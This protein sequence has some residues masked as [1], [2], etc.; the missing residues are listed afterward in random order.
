MKNKVMGKALSWVLSAAMALTMSGAIPAMTTNVYADGTAAGT[1]FASSLVKNDKIYLG[2]TTGKV[3]NSIVWDVIKEKSGDATGTAGYLNIMLDAPVVYGAAT[4]DGLGTTKGYLSSELAAQSALLQTTTTGENTDNDVADVTEGAAAGT[5]LTLVDT[6]ASSAQLYLP[7]NKE[8]NGITTTGVWT[9][10]AIKVATQAANDTNDYTKD[11]SAAYSTA[12][13][14]VAKKTSSEG[15]LAEA[16]LSTDSKTGAFLA[17]QTLANGPYYLT[18]I[19]SS[20]SAPKI[21]SVSKSD[22]KVT[23]VLNSAVMDGYTL[24]VLQTTSAGAFV[25]YAVAT[26]SATDTTS[27]TYTYTLTGDT[28]ATDMLSVVFEKDDA[29]MQET[30]YVSSPVSVDWLTAPTSSNFEIGSLEYAGKGQITADTILKK[31]SAKAYEKETSVGD[32][33]GTHDGS[34]QVLAYTSGDIEITSLKQ[35]TTEVKAAD[36]VKTAFN[37]GTYEVWG[38]ILKEGI[39][40]NS[41]ETTKPT[42][43]TTSSAIKIGDLKITTKALSAADITFTLPALAQYSH[44]TDKDLTYTVASLPL[45]LTGNFA[46]DKVNAT[47]VKVTLKDKDQTANAGLAA[48]ATSKVIIS[49]LDNSNFSISGTNMVISE[50]QKIDVTAA[51]MTGTSI[52][53]QPLSTYAVEGKQYAPT[54][55]KITATFEGGTTKEIAYPAVLNTGDEWVFSPA[56]TTVLTAGT[57]DFSVSYTD[58]AS[59]KTFAA[60]KI[61]VTVSEKEVDLTS[62]TIPKTNKIATNGTMALPTVTYNP[63]N[64][65]VDRSVTWTLTQSTLGTASFVDADGRPLGSSVGAVGIIGLKAGSVTLKAS[66]SGADSNEETV[67]VTDNNASVEWARLSGDTRYETAAAI[68]SEAFPDVAPTSAVLVSGNSFADA[69]SANALAGQLE[70]PLLLTD[71][72]SIPDATGA[73]IKK[74]N[75]ATIYIVGG[76]AV[77]SSSVE[78]MLKSASGYDVTNVKRIYGADRAGT[79]EAVITT[80]KTLNITWGDTVIVTTG[81]HAADALSVSSMCYSKGYP[82]LLASNGEL[83]GSS[84]AVAGNFT[85]AYVLGGTSAVSANAFAQLKDAVGS[86]PKRLSGN[87]RY[88]TSVAI[89]KEFFENQGGSLDLTCFASGYDENY[90]DALAAGMLAGKYSAPVLLINGTSGAGFDYVAENYTLADNEVEG[91]YF[92]GGTFAMPQATIN[93][94]LA[95]WETSKEVTTFNNI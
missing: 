1:K 30:H 81:D 64:T 66:V 41:D 27:K 60:G 54:G 53:T 84:L 4:M 89:A 59:G 56:L 75:L 71:K 44:N 43:G 45:T 21:T 78:S 74:W 91:L 25:A 49:A 61:S 55:L 80:G 62:I 92:L 28:K 15:F 33:I 35:G 26:K 72:D 88:E 47:N 2:S 86:T 46:D 40:N 79:A 34:S 10:N 57:Q 31:I 67:T 13:D 19:S 63:S 77:I 93:A 70:V 5:N 11:Y 90:P 58:K 29:N 42:F 22:D 38:K 73:L 17:T 69:L 48:A 20:I 39:G 94:V 76:P 83:S 52:T 14:F 68:A 37:V 6:K 18:L 8:V 87:D 16:N 65:T 50:E 36:F 3:D 82:L 23:V 12:G 7:S 95:N 24:K 32:V 9:R 85:K 51:K